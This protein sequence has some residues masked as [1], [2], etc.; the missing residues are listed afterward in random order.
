MVE[1]TNK[2]GG[3]TLRHTTRYDI[4]VYQRLVNLQQRHKCSYNQIVNKIL[5]DRLGIQ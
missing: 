2:W 3:K 4:Q 5:K 1:N